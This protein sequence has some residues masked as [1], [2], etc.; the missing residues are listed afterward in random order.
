M[1]RAAEYTVKKAQT[2]SNRLVFKRGK[3]WEA[4]GG[5]WRLEFGGSVFCLGK[6]GRTH[7][8]VA[9]ES[10][11]AEAEP[12]VVFRTSSLFTPTHWLLCR[13]SVLG[14]DWRE[15]ERSKQAATR[16]GAHPQLF[17]PKKY[18][19]PHF[20]TEGCRFVLPSAEWSRKERACWDSARQA[21]NWFLTCFG[22]CWLKY[23]HFGTFDTSVL[24]WIIFWA[25]VWASPHRFCLSFLLCLLSQA[26]QL[27]G[28]TPGSTPCPCPHL[29]PP[30][31]R[32]CPPPRLLSPATGRVLL[33]SVPPRGSWAATRGTATWTT[34][35]T[36]QRWA[37]YLPHICKYTR[38]PF[39]SANFLRWG[40]Q[41]HQIIGL[42]GGEHTVCTH[43]TRC[44]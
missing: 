13:P 16:H 5:K 11:C 25:H 10:P 12:G 29:P 34:T 37:G 14:W 6:V 22:Q 42:N 30:R 38:C 39:L 40:S 28:L 27:W 7:E 2:P 21:E 33:P 1:K 4:V 44:L 8:A 36:W 20:S 24:N 41:F 26:K 9:V 17:L 18:C 35:S 3:I 23:R 32:R 15:T 43:R 19:Q 31:L